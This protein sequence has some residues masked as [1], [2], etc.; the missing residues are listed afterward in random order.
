M[1][2]FT[3][4]QVQQP[5]HLGDHLKKVREAAGLTL[6]DLADKTKIQTKY[7]IKLENGDY[8]NFLANVYIQGFLKKY[9]EILKL[10]I[11]EILKEYEKERNL[12]QSLK[13]ALN[14]HKNLPSL[15]KPRFIITTHLINWCLIAVVLFL[16]GG[17]FFYQI[18][19]L[20][21]APGL[22]VFS[23]AAISFIQENQVEIKGKTEIGSRL[24][25]N[26]QEVYIDTEG[27][28]EENIFLRLG[29]N[30]IT[31]RSQNKFNKFNEKNIK[32]IR[33]N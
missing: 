8:E 28:F 17:Y 4:R 5:P 20:F 19:F 33:N 16:V 25:I 9:A 30:E 21:K 11:V 32:V 23:P 31:V 10:D 1:V 27:N 26:N 2:D 13:N 22:D 24:T 12:N 7:L 15:K 18:R 6:A 14:Y 29:L 3:S